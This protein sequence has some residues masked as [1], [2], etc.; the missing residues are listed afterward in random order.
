MVWKDDK[1]IDSGTLDG[2]YESGASA[3]NSRGQVVGFATN[4]IADPDSMVGV[5]FNGKMADLGNFGGTCTFAFDLN[6]RDQVV[7]G[8]RLTGDQEQHPF[9]WN[10]R[11][12]VDLG[13]FG[14]GLGNAIALKDAGDVTGFAT[15]PGDEIVHAALW[16]HEKASDLGTL[17]G[18]AS[19]IGFDIDERG[20]VVGISTNDFS[21]LNQC[22]AFLW[23]PGGPMLDLND[24]VSGSSPATGVAGDYQRSRR[25]RGHRL[26]PRWESARLHLGSLWQWPSGN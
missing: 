11:K 9:L 21:D 23:Q 14:G 12:L 19:S 24:L 3:V 5:G 8:S 20:D 16:S 4:T 17:G 25:D 7:G 10:G 13:T 22:R 15:Y 26:G 6:N 18:D 1:I 2:G